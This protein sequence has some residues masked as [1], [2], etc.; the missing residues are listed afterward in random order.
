M[1]R[2]TSGTVWH[3]R[4]NKNIIFNATVMLRK[5]SGNI[6]A[7]LYMQEKIEKNTGLGLQSMLFEKESGISIPN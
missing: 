7:T 3:E 6:A 2:Q 1:A 5:W 4:I